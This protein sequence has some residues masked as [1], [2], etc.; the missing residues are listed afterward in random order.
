[1]ESMTASK[2]NTKAVVNNFFKNTDEEHLRI[3]INQKMSKIISYDIN[4][5]T[6][7]QK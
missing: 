5:E 7:L 1:M 2:K 3:I 6:N 4:K